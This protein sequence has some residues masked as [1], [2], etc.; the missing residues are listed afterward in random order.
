MAK[1]SWLIDDDGDIWPGD[2]VA[3][4]QSMRSPLSAGE[5]AAH[6]IAERGYVLV[7]VGFGRFELMFD[8]TSVAPPALTSAIYW[9]QGQEFAPTRV[10]HPHD[11]ALVSLFP[12][13]AGLT[14]FLSDQLLKRDSLSRVSRT[15]IPLQ[16]SAFATRWRAAISICE[17]LPNPRPR[18]R[19]LGD[20]F[21]GYFSILQRNTSG[22][23]CTIAHLG[24]G[25]AAWEPEFYASAV[26]RTFRD[27][28]DKNAGV[29]FAD[30]YR[31]LARGQFEPLA[32]SVRA[33]INSPG[34]P[35]RRINYDRMVLPIGTSQLLVAN[36]VH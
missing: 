25:Y 5:I 20:M 35:A 24:E 3:L 4:A 33:Q 31:D 26:G 13:R 16:Q 9:F 36:F 1:C 11:P 19:L 34:K 17:E 30:G 7:S 21:Q 8:H 6:L 14:T 10:L 32:E 23:D 27:V 29:L 2:G 22:D 18:H 28:F 12:T 15:T